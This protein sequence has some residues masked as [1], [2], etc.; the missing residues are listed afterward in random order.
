LSEREAKFVNDGF[1]NKND[2][3]Y[4]SDDNET[5]DGGFRQDNQPAKS[6]RFGQENILW[7]RSTHT[8]PT[9]WTLCEEEN[10]LMPEEQ[11]VTYWPSPNQARSCHSAPPAALCSPTPQKHR[12]S[13]SNT[14]SC[15]SFNTNGQIDNEAESTSEVPTNYDTPSTSKEIDFNCLFSNDSQEFQCEQ[16]DKKFRKASELHFHRQTH[17]IEQQ[18]NTKNRS[19]QCP[20]CKVVHRSRAHLEKHLLEQHE[21]TANL[22]NS[23]PINDLDNLTNLVA[24][25]STASTLSESQSSIQPNM[26]KYCCIDCGVGFRTHG[27]LVKHL[28]TKNHIKS[29]AQKGKLPEDAMNLIKEN[30]NILASL[31]ASNC[32]QARRSLLS[33]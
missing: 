33:K 28:R 9:L 30:S 5:E 12:Q 24:S 18:Q 7:Q 25:G 21:S 14:A 26:R 20:E 29:L 4:G 1:D 10:L 17:L 16:C 31:N 19:Y 11:P 32:E 13:G 3:D 6:W 8:P 2:D 27:V 23:S 15:L 22:D